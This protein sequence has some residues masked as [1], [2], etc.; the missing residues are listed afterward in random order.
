MM[1]AIFRKELK[2]CFTSILGWVYL[3]IF[4]CVFG[5]FFSY[6]NIE[7]GSQYIAY[8]ISNTV[9]VFIIVIPLLSMRAFAEEKKHKTDQLLFTSA[10]STGRIVIAKYLAILCLLLIGI[11][12]ISFFP[13]I[14]SFKGT[15]PIGET[16][17]SLFG[18]FLFGAAC[19]AI[20]FFASAIAESQ[21]IA[22]ILSAVL[23]AIGV[24]M[25]FIVDA[26][27]KDMKVLTAILQSLDLSVP[28]SSMI[29]G[30]MDISDILYYIT[31]I[32]IFLLLSDRMILKKRMIRTRFGKEPVPAI[33][34]GLMITFGILLNVCVSQ[35]PSSYKEIDFTEERFYTLSDSTI[36]FLQ[37]I[38]EPVT[39]Y[40]LSEKAEAD[41]M[42]SKILQRFEQ[43]TDQITVKYVN[44]DETIDF[45]TQYTTEA[46]SDNSLIFSSQNKCATVDYE[47][48]YVKDIS[49]YD[50]YSTY[51]TFP[52]SGFDAE[53]QF[54]SALNY[55]ECDELP[56]VYVLEGEDEY[57][58][59]DELL[60]RIYKENIELIALNLCDVTSIPD[61]AEAIIIGGPMSDFT[62]EEIAVINLY[63][64]NGG[65]AMLLYS[66]RVD[67][68]LVNYESLV[69]NLGI[70]VEA[71]VVLESNEDQY[72]YCQWYIIPTFTENEITTYLSE[73]NI[74][75]LFM[76]SKGFKTKDKIKSVVLTP[77]LETTEGAFS[78]SNANA[79]AITETTGNEIADGDIEGPFYCGYSATKQN[80]ND[81]IS[82][83]FI[84][85]SEFIYDADANTVTTDANYILLLN[86]LNQLVDS[87][88]KI[89]IPEKSYYF[90]NFILF[91]YKETTIW[92]VIT[93]GVLP[94]SIL[95]SG[96]LFCV[97]RRRKY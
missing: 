62:E 74:P 8:T 56:I 42:I 3:A 73:N 85:G 14:Q 96:I 28:L 80:D 11:I 93:I 35:I 18:F 77:L 75:I 38:K 29:N 9:L 40:V 20:G 59:P 72:Y 54:V 64:E 69:E 33:A 26:V 46:L 30:I 94:I 32:V 90:N 63:L 31:I 39:I 45:T 53:G 70:E 55:L 48:C 21:V 16:F 13:I 89:S 60:N 50:Y 82:K 78:V 36:E 57:T 41:S 22:A 44:P 19:L 95:L 92:K 58:M 87:K 84:L 86:G 2:S 5:L 67:E 61:N 66:S 12:I 71:G 52:V 79:A 7:F 68:A 81:T 34:V 23:I 83:Y 17:L 25:G 27:A 97:I 76:Y 4:V 10:V 24:F 51:G 47:D 37:E 43:Q 88:N 6:Y 91:S 15:I 1:S 65:N 49:D